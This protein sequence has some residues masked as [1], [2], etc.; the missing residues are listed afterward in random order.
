MFRRDAANNAAVW[1]DHSSRVNGGAVERHEIEAFLTL[2]EELHFG[3][4]AERLLVSRSH[5]TQTIQKLERRIGAQLFERTSRRVTLTAIGRRLRAD[6][7][8]G[9]ERIQAGVGRA[10]ASAKGVTGVLRV[11]FAGAAA[12]QAA[13]DAVAAFHALHPDC[14]VKLH[15]LQMNDFLERLRADAV[16]VA[17]GC[18]PV[19]EPDLAS[20]PVLFTEARMLA[21]S[22]GHPFAGRTSVSL[23]DLAR[24]RLLQPPVS[25]PGYWRSDHAPVATPSGRPVPAGPATETVQ[26]ALAMVG[27]G[28]GMLVVGAQATRYY[29]RPGVV[30]LPIR[31]A[32]PF[33]WGPVWRT[34]TARVRAFTAAIP[35]GA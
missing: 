26:E 6:V 29:A 8:P 12:G 23:E 20:G 21:V 35:G 9:W 33:E 18:F 19:R 4:T 14:Q 24:D 5:V 22:S 2:A 15:E 28:A 32:P 7:A 30:Y 25:L 16:D 3:R 10:I 31:D 34:E 27:A 1:N 17:I 13:A 11:G